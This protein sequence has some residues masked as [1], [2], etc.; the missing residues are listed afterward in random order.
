MRT[1]RAMHLT[2]LTWLAATAAIAVVLGCG[3]GRAIFNVD[4]LS[5]IGGEGRDT[6]HYTVPGGTS[7]TVDNPPVQ[8]TLLQGLGNSTVDAVT[9]ALAANVE[10]A[11]GAGKVKFQIFFS[12]SSAGLYSTT[13]YA[14]DSANVSGA[15]TAIL[16]VDSVP[17]VADS[18]F[19]Q[20]QIYVGVRVAVTAN[21]P[22]LP[23]M[24]GRLRLT[25]VRL[26]IIL[27]DQVF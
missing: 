25:K 20:D 5:F 6:V 11:T 12:S 27:Q 9:L 22:A 13:P 3:E 23:A 24:D 2:R 15:D 7:G 21:A 4:V 16:A 1:P 8:V 10:N 18:I 17:L 14:Q 26:R 19:G